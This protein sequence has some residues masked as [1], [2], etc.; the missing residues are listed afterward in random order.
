NNLGNV[1]MGNRI[2]SDADR[3]LRAGIAYC[4]DRD[5]DHWRLIMSGSLARSLAEQGHYAAAEQYLAEVMRHP[6]TSPPTRVDALAIAGTL[7]AR[8]T[9]DGAAGLDEALQIAIRIGDAT[10][11]VPVAAARAEAAWIAGRLSDITAEIDRAWPVAVAHPRPWELGELSWWLN[12]G[13][14]N[15]QAPIPVAQPFALMLAG[16]HRAA[17]GQWRALGCPLWSAYALARS[18]RMPDAH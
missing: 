12:A 9:G 7:T 8:R 14:E 16:E 4:A 17:A 10:E 3:H 1:D 2:F 5:L 13:G 15:R 18:L 6:D 11:L